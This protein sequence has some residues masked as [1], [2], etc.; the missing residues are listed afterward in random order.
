ME[1]LNQAR[2]QAIFHGLPAR[3]LIRGDGYVRVPF[4]AQ[5]VGA[6]G[7]SPEEDAIR[8]SPAPNGSDPGMAFHA[9]LDSR[10]I[11]RFI[12]VNLVEQMDADEVEVV[13]YPSGTSD[14]F[15]I[16][17]EDPSGVRAIS[18]DPVTAFAEV[19]VIR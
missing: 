1:G 18:V 6:G 2:A 5:P 4:P 7:S 9:T 12:G 17:L 13:F 14:D 8:S 3:F 10:V 16:V 11:I 15:T 19:K